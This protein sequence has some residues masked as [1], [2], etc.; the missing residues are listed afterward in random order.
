MKILTRI[1]LTLCAILMVNAAQAEPVAIVNAKA[2][3]MTEAGIVDNATIIMD[4]GNIVAMGSSV[5]VPTGAMVI[6]AKGRM[7]TPAL[8]NSVSQLGLV[9]VGSADDTNDTASL[10]SGMGAAFDIRYALNGNSV[11]I[12]IAR[13]D[14]LVRA[15]AMPQGTMKTPF[16]GTAS[17]LYLRPGVDVLDRA[18]VAVAVKIG[19]A[20]T[21]GPGHSRAADWQLLRNALDDARSYKASPTAYAAAPNRLDL[22]ALEPVL[23]G[24]ALLVIDTMR[25]SDIRQ[26]VAVA[27]AYAVR[28]ALMGAA[29][30]WR[31]A[32]L[33]AAKN[34][35]VILDPTLNMPAT[36]DELGARQDSAAILAKAGVTLAFVPNRLGQNYNA[37]TSLR[38]GAGIAVANG[39]EWAQAL[40]AI[41]VNPARIWGIADRYGALEAGKAA[42]VVIWD[43]DPLEVTS[44]PVAVLIAG[45]PI[46]LETR[47]TKLRDRYAPRRANGLP[48]VYR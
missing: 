37:G 6:D 32:D 9:E 14:G 2:V 27:D 19:G 16:L 17:L 38:E 1:L 21:R 25:E 26:A 35:P 4:G 7:V 33:L 24:K 18:A 11:L 5:T 39:L 34:I 12:D 22:A 15:V 31:V 3:T 48:P 46:S 13:A 43:G 44:A 40:A 10:D 45:K 29:E 30:A 8:M 42:D 20:V 41:T 47:Q 36:F 28:V 23:D